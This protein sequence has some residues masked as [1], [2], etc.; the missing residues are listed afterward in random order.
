M[1]FHIPSVVQAVPAAIADPEPV[2]PVL[3]GA[4]AGADAAGVEAAGAAGDAAGLD[5]E[6]ARVAAD[7]VAIVTNTPP[8]GAVL[9]ATGAG[10]AEVAGGVVAGAAGDAPPVAAGA[11]VAAT[12]PPK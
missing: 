10:E 11:P 2:V 3:A 9:E 1:Q 4:G 12:A 7:E 6:V 8:G 5:A